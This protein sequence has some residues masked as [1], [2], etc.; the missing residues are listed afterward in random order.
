M[1]GSLKSKAYDHA[2]IAAFVAATACLLNAC[3]NGEPPRAATAPKASPARH[4]AA[5]P[6]PLP[7]GAEPVAI[8]F[9]SLSREEGLRLTIATRGDADGRT[10]F[11]TNSCCGIEDANRFVR[12]VRIRASGRMLRIEKS[13]EGWMVAHGP[14][15]P[16]DVSY[17]LPPTGTTR[18]DTGPEDQFRPLVNDGW[19]HLIG[20][21]SLLLPVRGAGTDT[22]GL[23]IDAS[24]VTGSGQFASS[25][26]PGSVVGPLPATRAQLRRAL[27]LGGRIHLRV[28]ENAGGKIG[29]AYSGMRPD[30]RR[31]DLRRDVR[32]IVDAVRRF[33]RATQPWYLISVHGGTPRN[34]RINIGGGTGLTDA[35]AMFVASGLDFAEPEERE[36]FRWVLAHEYI[37]QWIGLTVRVANLSGSENDDASVYWFSEGVTDFYTMRVLTRAGLQRPELSLDVLNDRLRRYSDNPKRNLSAKASGPLFWSDP[38]AEQIPYL[39]GY[40]AAWYAD[41]AIGRSALGDGRGL[42][43]PILALVERAEAEPGFRV[44]TTFLVSHFGKDMSPADA[45]TFRDFVVS[46][47]KAPL[48]EDAFL[49][50]LIP[51]SGVESGPALQFDFSDPENKTCFRH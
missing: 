11:S 20:D 18:I 6:P 16:L 22:I 35:F 41:L 46:G 45:R 51:R 1:T 26:G 37:H 12:D 47:G 7:S 27:Y 14:G 43:K 25:F 15:T 24:R 29:I 3:G 2:M 36:Q 44:D 10:T 31:E 8:R 48:R 50:C 13:P 23:R 4:P 40:L 32:G 30:L 33:F 19:F 42:D 39:R 38:D 34:E 49:P 9:D 21:S 17:R 5:D 28:E